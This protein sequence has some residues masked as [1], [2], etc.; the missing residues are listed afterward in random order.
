MVEMFRGL[1]QQAGK[2]GG[3]DSSVLISPARYKANTTRANDNVEY[4]ARWCA[5]DVDEFECTED[6]KSCI[7]PIVGDYEYVVYSTASS[8]KDQPKFRLCFPLSEE[9]RAQDIKH[10]WFALNSEF[11]DLAID[12]QTKDL[13]RMFYV[14]ALYPNAYNFFFTNKGHTIYPQKLMAKWEYVEPSGNSFLDS[15]SPEMRDALI[16]YRK[17]QL[18]NTDYSWSSYEDCPFIPKKMIM[19]YKMISGTGW[20]VKMY[21]I[22]VAMACNAIEKGYPITEQEIVSVCKQLDN[23][24]GKWYDK[25][26]FTTEAGRALQYAFGQTG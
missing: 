4:W 11:K 7:D 15:L 26:A 3:P 14:P 8:T 12:R 9:V 19:D 13:S 10:F 6:V 1:S 23:D 5:L 18:T 20:Y 2:K 17:N 21:Q 24:T 16:E 22:M 25:R